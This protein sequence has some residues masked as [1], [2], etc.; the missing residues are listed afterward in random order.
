V[1]EL[2]RQ[3]RASRSRNLQPGLLPAAERAPAQP[4]RCGGPISQR[5]AGWPCRTPCTTSVG[6]NRARTTRHRSAS[7]QTGGRYRPLLLKTARQRLLS[8]PAEMKRLPAQHTLS[9]ET[10]ATGLARR[11]GCKQAASQPGAQRG[12]SETSAAHLEPASCCPRAVDAP[13]GSVTT[14]AAPRP[15][16][17][18]TA[19][20]PLCPC[21]T[22]SC[23]SDNPRPVPLPA[24][25]VV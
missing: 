3:G 13:A 12:R 23:E 25:F 10:C 17:L 1:K 21:V 22:I 18:S 24:G 5:R 7:Q 16:S 20:V 6:N 4:S 8:K 11:P 9:T 14:N 15:A 19:S 2:R